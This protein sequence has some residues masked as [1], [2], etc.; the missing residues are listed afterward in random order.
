M[1][2]NVRNNDTF[3]S[4]L[5]GQTY[6][7]TA[8]NK[9]V[10]TMQLVTDEQDESL[11]VV[12]V[13]VE[14]VENFFQFLGNDTPDPGPQAG[15][16]TLE[17]GVLRRNGERIETGTL[18][19]RKIIAEDKHGIYVAVKALS[20][21]KD[22]LFFIDHVSGFFYKIPA[23]EAMRLT[24]VWGTRNAQMF[25][26]HDEYEVTLP[27]EE[28]QEPK[29]EIAVAEEIVGLQG[30]RIIMRFPVR[31]GFYHGVK[32]SLLTEQETEERK[33][34]NV[35]F[36]SEVPLI[37]A[38]DIDGD[39][40]WLANKTPAGDG[41]LRKWNTSVT[42]Y[43]ITFDKEDGD[44]LEGEPFRPVP[45]KG[46]VEKLAPMYGDGKNLMVTTTRGIAYTNYPHSA[47]YAY[48]EDVMEAAATH[49]VPLKVDIDG[50]ETT[51]VL[52]NEVY[53]V[54]TV[55]VVLTRD[56]GYVTKVAEA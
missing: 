34:V 10:V 33:T 50:R 36:I 49:P 9:E 46:V 1:K 35:Y 56:R 14:K 43:S 17:N 5:N 51:F 54:A 29:K 12:S 23:T 38:V 11:D 2:K 4:L 25:L 45:V 55:S 53:D 40:C 42:G 3:K 32:P 31:D 52:G 30:S 48:G 22:E 26:L 19:L 7:V 18:S 39:R 13:P 37:E 41:P 21:N 20:G 28:G 44:A 8:A 15:E 27:A 6:V 47:R 16:Y 24:H